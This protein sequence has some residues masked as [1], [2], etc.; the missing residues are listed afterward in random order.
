[1]IKIDSSGKIIWESNLFPR[2]QHDETLNCVANCSDSGVIAVGI[3]SGMTTGAQ[4]YYAIKTDKN[5]NTFPTSIIKINSIISDDYIMYQNYPNPFNPVTHLEFGIPDL[6]FVLLKIYDILGKEVAVLINEMLSPGIY[7]STFNG[8]NFASGVYFYRLVV[9]PSNP[10]ES[11]DFSEI[12]RM[13][14]IK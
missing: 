9:S 6:G 2:P 7:K 1:M 14:L 5:G 12:K 11:G 13:V 4:D 10:M 8:S 3:N